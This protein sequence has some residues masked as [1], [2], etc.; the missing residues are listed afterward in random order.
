MS[1]KQV[2]HDTQ[3]PKLAHELHQELPVDHPDAFFRML[4]KVIRFAICVLAL[5]MVAVILWGVGDVMYI[6]YERLMQPP[7]FLLDVN[8][9][10]Y[11]FGGFMAV[12]IAVEIFINIRM[13]LGSNVFP[14][15]LVVAT[16]LMAIARKVIILDFDTLTPLYLIGIAATTLALGITY[17][18]LGKAPNDDY[19]H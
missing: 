6:I 3:K 9:I 1:N 13:Y 16:A 14:V 11:T 15:K 2:E 19:D 5:C 12:L 17:W 8:D 10:F 7:Y 4:H 18:L